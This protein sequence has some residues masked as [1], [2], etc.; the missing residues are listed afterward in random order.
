MAAPDVLD[1]GGALANSDRVVGPL[2]VTVG[3][4][5][6]ANVVRE[7]RLAALPL[8]AWLLIA[9]WLL[10]APTPAL[11]SNMATGLAAGLLGFV[12]GRPGGSYGGGWRA[13]WSSESPYRDID[14]QDSP[15]EQPTI[16]QRER[17]VR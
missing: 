15:D 7:V 10:D 17:Q 11:I 14:R 5:A 4:I 8:A 3:G 16:K 12:R 2:L 13:V 9:P 1:Y 6:A